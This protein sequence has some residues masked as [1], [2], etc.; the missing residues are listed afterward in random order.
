MAYILSGGSVTSFAEADD[1]TAQDARFFE[2]N[3][4]LDTTQGGEVEDLLVKSTD[5]IV[6][7]LKASAWWRQYMNLTVSA[8]LGSYDI[9]NPDKDKFVLNDQRLIDLCVYHTLK[10]YLYPKYADFGVESS[11]EVQKIRYYNDKFE[12]LWLE[13]LAS[14]D[15]YDNSGDGSVASDEKMIIPQLRRRTRGRRPIGYVR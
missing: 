9:P 2:A 13:L 14:G 5:R 4:G 7:K 12:T 10:E 3:E 11:A 15:F 1:V 6:S 8:T